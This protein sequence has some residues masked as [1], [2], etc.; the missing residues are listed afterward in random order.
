MI[1]LI[2]GLFLI[3]MMACNTASP[4]DSDSTQKEDW[5]KLFDG[6]STKG[7]HNYGKTSIGSAW[8]VEDGCLHLDASK[9]DGWQIKDG[10]DIV[11]DAEFE[12]FHLKLEW[13][14]AP[15]GNSGIMF[16]VKED[17]TLY[18]YPWQTGPEMQV[19]DNN[20]HPDAKIPK[21]R[22]GDLYD[23]IACEQETV[24]PAGEWNLAEIKCK[25][26]LLEF[27][28]NGTKVVQTTLWNDDWKSLVKQ[29]KFNA[30]P[31]FG[32]YQK[33]KIALQ[34]HG[35]DVWYRNIMIQKL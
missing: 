11:T 25:N 35:D 26:G 16:F 6:V 13:K 28:L 5:V 7:W 2:S 20:G 34:D 15:N 31:G 1:K 29:S 12:N 17:T 4:N 10:G 3:T 21:H 22:A 33:G 14:I 30:F 18:K 8:K 23:L 32:T 27:W 19:L 9:K 24:K